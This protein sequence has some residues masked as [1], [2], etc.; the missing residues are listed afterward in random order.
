MIMMP[1]ERHDLGRELGGA[2]DRQL[3]PVEPQ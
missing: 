2:A 1:I 3:N